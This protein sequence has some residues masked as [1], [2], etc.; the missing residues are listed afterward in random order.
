MSEI[1]TGI[2]KQ[3][4]Y[5]LCFEANTC[6]DKRVYSKILTAYKNTKNFQ[7]KNILKS[8]LQ[9]AKTAYEKKR[10]LCQDTGQV[11]VF[12]EIGQEVK[13]TGDFIEDAINCAVEKCYRENFFRKSVVKNAVFDRENTNTNTPAI[14]YTKYVKGNGISIKVLIKGAGSENKSRLEMLLPTLNEEETVSACTD[15]I[16]SAGINACPPMFIG[17]GIGGTADRACIMSKEA[18]VCG[19]FT[20]E[21]QNLA[22]KI[23]DNVNSKA[24]EEYK[25]SYVLEVKLL[26]SSTHIACMPIAVTINCHSDR[27]SSCLIEENNIIYDHQIPEFIEIP[28]DKTILKEIKANDINELRKLKEGEEFLLTGKIIVARDMAH[29]RIYELIKKGEELPFDI[30]NSIIFYAGPCPNK[31][32][33]VIGS[34]GPTTASRMDKYSGVFYNKGMFASIGKGIRSEEI[35][36][37]IKANNAKY[38]TVTG[39]IAALLAEKVKTCEVIAFNDLG[40]EAVYKLYVEK[41]PLKTS[42][43]R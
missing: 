6:L 40:A 16:L 37:V 7:T 38:F 11:I 28:E 30:R 2:I 18:L 17:I 35:K 14:I 39:G 8:I 25:D 43:S 32:N 15:M 41:F 26:S 9:N 4:V 1:S 36:A 19:S 24:P 31:P 42:I 10:P 27:T 13:L 33:E 23:Q 22:R 34:I 3:A 29:K 12:V 20:N 5:R 21:E